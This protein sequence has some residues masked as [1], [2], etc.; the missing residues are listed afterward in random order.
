MAYLAK[1]TAGP[2]RVIIQESSEGFYILVFERKGSQAPEKDYLQDTM[3]LAMEVCME[4]YG[5]S[6]DSWQH[7]D[8]VDLV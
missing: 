6:R 2:H 4:D 5:I 7:I 8:D 3:D 1:P